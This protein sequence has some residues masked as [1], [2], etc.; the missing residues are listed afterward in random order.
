[1]QAAVREW[2][3]PS[4]TKSKWNDVVLIINSRLKVDVLN[5]FRHTKLEI[6]VIKKL[7]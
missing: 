4:Q 2:L 5:Y 3:E 1:M 7:A 6:A